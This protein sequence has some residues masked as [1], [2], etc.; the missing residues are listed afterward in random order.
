MRATI[1]PLIALFTS[2]F[3]LYLGN[4]LINVFLPIRME[5]ESFDANSIGMV[6]SLYS[7]GALLGALY[8]K[9]LIKRA[10]HIRMFAGCVALGTISVL[11]CSLYTDPIL[12]GAMRVFIGFCNASAA[13]A[14][15][16]WLSGSSDKQTRGKVLGV[17]NAVVLGGLFLGQFLLNAADPAGTVLFVATGILLCTAIIPMVLSKNKGPIV[18]DVTSMSIKDLYRASPLGVISCFASGIIYQAIFNMLPIFANDFGIVN[19]QLS[20]FMGAAIFGAFVLQFPVGYL[21][22]RFDRRTVLMYLLLISAGVGVI[23]SVFAPLDQIWIAYLGAAVTCGI[24]ACTYPLSVS[25]TFDTLKQNQ[26]VAASGKLIVIFSI[27]GIMGPYIASMTMD[28]FGSTA[29]FYFLGIVQFCLAGFVAYRMTVRDALPVEQQESFV[30]QATGTSV[31]VELDPRTEY[32]EPVMPMSKEAKTAVA[33]A[34]VDPAAAVKMAR[35]IAMTNPSKGSEVAAAVAD[36]QGIDVLRL[37]EVM[38]EVVPYQILDI[39]RSIVTAKPELAYELVTK[40]AETHPNQ[41]VSIA[42]EIGR[43]LPDIRVEMARVAAEAAPESVT[44]V[45]EYYAQVLAE[46]L[47]ATRPADMVDDTSV[48]DAADIASELWDAAPE[49]AMDVAVAMV[50]AVPEAAVSVTE[51]FMANA[52]PDAEE[53]AETTTEQQDETEELSEAEQNAQNDTVELVTRLAEVAPE[54]AVD[55]AVAAVEAMPESAA[56]V[57][58]GVAASM[59]SH[60]VDDEQAAEETEQRND[61]QDDDQ[62]EEQ[63]GNEAAVELVHRINEVAPDQ[64]AVDVAVAVVEAMPESAADVAAEIASEMAS[65]QEDADTESVSDTDTDTGEDADKNTDAESV[66]IAEDEPSAEAVADTEQGISDNDAAVELVQRINEVAPDTAVDVAV[67]VVEALP[68]AAADVAAGMAADISASHEESA[69][70]DASAETAASSE[71]AEEHDAES[72]AEEDSETV[73]EAAVELVQ[74]IAEAA[75]ENTV[76]VAAAVVEVLPESASDIVDAISAGDESVDGEWAQ[77]IDDGPE[78]QA[79]DTENGTDKPAG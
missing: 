9:E 21:S 78:Q 28:A 3:I 33:I 17:Y 75:P 67:A 5:L 36:V 79:E 7:V 42:A 30:M 18:E 52:M 37:Y 20:L 14:M 74:R 8:S 25:Q 16:S 41:V 13:T 66:S 60:Q 73:S 71:S 46:E 57:A 24:I 61:V 56:D 1:L 29:L 72:T 6:L 27:G 40:L 11:I 48:Q 47:E 59:V 62:S 54:Q 50:D 4:G 26:M 23:V 43:A 49:Q 58:A 32:K 12:W 35:A 15:E 45:A 70:E 51:G 2:C 64:A 44:Q 68:D 19:F 34:E 31:A 53:S 22:D 39:T 69:E 38:K 77:S 63:T 55:V 10:G 76:D 65:Q